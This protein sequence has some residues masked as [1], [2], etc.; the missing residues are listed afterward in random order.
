MDGWTD[1]RTDGWRDG[2]TDGRM[3]GR[4]DG[5]MDGRTDGWMDGW[6]DGWMDGRTDGWRDGW[7]DN[8]MDIIMKRYREAY[9][10]RCI[11]EQRNWKIMEFVVI[12][13]VYILNSLFLSLL[14]GSQYSLQCLLKVI[15]NDCSQITGPT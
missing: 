8:D 5:W 1:G 12:N 10:G 9:V 2:R 3:D 14:L 11:D 15:F 7:M 4:T 13:F 6:T